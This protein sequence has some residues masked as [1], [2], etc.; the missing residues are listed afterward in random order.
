MCHS[1]LMTYMYTCK[2]LNTSIHLHVMLNEMK[3][4][5]YMFIHVVHE[6]QWGVYTLYMYMYSTLATVSASCTTSIIPISFPVA[7][8]PYGMMCK[9]KPS[10]CHN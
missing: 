7:T 10:L 5:K 4:P 6:L 9:S 1:K 2:L 3:S 8:Q